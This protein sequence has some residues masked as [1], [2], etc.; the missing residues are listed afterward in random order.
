MEEFV[1]SCRSLIS[2]VR[3]HTTPC[4]LHFGI[5]ACRGRELGG[6]S[7]GCMVSDMSGGC[8]VGLTNGGGREVR[9]CDWNM[10]N[11]FSGFLGITSINSKITIVFNIGYGVGKRHGIAILWAL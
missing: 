4:S 8:G 2:W 1:D 6:K 11:A 7:V 9:S 10:A 3:S 5:P